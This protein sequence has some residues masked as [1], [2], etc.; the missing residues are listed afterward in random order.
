MQKTKQKKNNWGDPDMFLTGYVRFSKL[1]L[2]LERLWILKGSSEGQNMWLF[3]VC[4]FVYEVDWD[5]Q[6]GEG[7]DSSLCSLPLADLAEW[8]I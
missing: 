4:M 6:D 5:W 7:T 1:M 8:W 2:S 3:Y